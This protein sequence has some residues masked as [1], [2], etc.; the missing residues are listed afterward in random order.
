MFIKNKEMLRILI[1]L[2]LVVIS[3]SCGKQE[4]INKDCHCGTIINDGIIYEQG[5]NQYWFD[6]ENS[7]S[8]KIKRINSSPEIW[9]ETYNG[10]LLCIEDKQKW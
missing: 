5:K 3:S 8:G 1:G 6:V 7:C 2:S 10:D 4:V 9:S